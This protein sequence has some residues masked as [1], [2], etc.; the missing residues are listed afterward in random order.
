MA[1]KRPKS[2]V[3][4]KQVQSDAYDGVPVGRLVLAWA[5]VGVPLVYGVSQVFIKSLALFQ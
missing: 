4:Q 5:V 2:N 3:K 1:S